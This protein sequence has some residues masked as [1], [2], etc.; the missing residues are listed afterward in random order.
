MLLPPVGYVRPDS[1]RQ[2]GD[3]LAADPNAVVLAGG[4]TLLNVLK[5]RLA[6]PSSLIDISRLDELRG[7][8]QRREDGVWIG[9]GATYD[10]VAASQ[11]VR[12]ACPPVAAVAERLVDRQVRARGT[13]GGNTCLNDPGSNYPPLLVAFGATMH[14]YGPEGRRDIA[15]DAFFLA[16]YL[17]AL[18]PGE[19]LEGITV[20]L[21]RPGEG[22]G[23]ASLQASRD[24]WALARACVWLRGNGLVED[25]RVVVGC[26]LPSPARQPLAEQALRNAAADEG[27]ADE[28]ARVAGE[29]VE[30]LSDVHAGRDYRLKML[31]AMVGRAV[32]QALRE[33]RD[34]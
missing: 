7:I 30:P 18:A 5:L 20:P 10:E 23:Y 17:T 32:R 6:R 4:Q 19:L 28:A 33:R 25:A 26:A 21:Q 27:A 31:K 29:G 22:I 12:N 1:L 15:A 34:G 14:I 13:I 8:E 24:S 11:V 2:A 16:P 3:A 9:A